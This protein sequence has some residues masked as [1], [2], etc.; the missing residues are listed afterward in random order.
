MLGYDAAHALARTLVM[1][2]YTAILE[3]TYAR[4]EQRASLRGAVPTASSPALWVVEFMISPDEAVERFRR[5]REATDLDEA[6]LRERVENFPYWDGALRI[7]SSSADTR[8]L[9]D[10]VITWLQGQPASAD[11]T[12]WVEAGRAW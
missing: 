11:W 4:R 12:G 5:R 9:A 2:E 3:C 1:H 7:D 10:Q 8:G 6:S